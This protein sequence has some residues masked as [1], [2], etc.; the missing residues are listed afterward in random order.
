MSD[1]FNAKNP[2]HRQ[3]L[4]AY[5]PGIRNGSYVMGY[6]NEADTIGSLLDYIDTLEAQVREG[7]ARQQMLVEAA[8]KAGKAL[9]ETTAELDHIDRE[10]WTKA[11]NDASEMQAQEM[12]DLMRERD[13]LATQL[14]EEQELRRYGDIHIPCRGDIADI[15]AQLAAAEGRAQGYDAAKHE[16]VNETG[17]G[18]G[19]EPARAIALLRERRNACADRADRAEDERDAALRDA[20][21]A[22]ERAAE[23][24]KLADANAGRVKYEH[25][26]ADNAT[27][28][29]EALRTQLA[30]AE[31]ARDALRTD[32][33]HLQS[34]IIRSGPPAPTTIP[35]DLSTARPIAEECLQRGCGHVRAGEA[36]AERDRWAQQAQ[37]TA[38][39]AV[40][41]IKRAEAARDAA[42]RDRAEAE[43]YIG[44][45]RNVLQRHPPLPA[46][47]CVEAQ[48][49]ETIVR[50]ERAL[51]R[52][53]ER[54][55]ALREENERL[56]AYVEHSKDCDAAREVALMTNP[57]PRLPCICGLREV[58][59][60]L[61]ATAPA[62]E[63][64]RG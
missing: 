46:I 53:E 63:K 11:F 10:G 16:A 25:E 32:L 56:R 5:L 59:D 43:K 51:Q 29:C 7:Q 12:A 41:N 48:V 54:V 13:A 50:L 33:H 47:G 2:A 1:A 30:E 8:V 37:M 39:D 44:N 27:R 49:E 36:E 19:I 28:A 21:E 20:A 40:A 6:V 14:A 57:I 45:V 15:K 4:R 42:L 24:R 9:G 34:G 18:E 58:L 64:P 26:R 52:S 62:E 55:G 38:E 35:P 60:G 3:G 22:R 23:Y 31:A 61:T 17:F